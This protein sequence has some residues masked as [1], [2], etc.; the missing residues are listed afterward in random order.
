M[1][2]EGH[3]TYKLAWN[4]WCDLLGGASCDDVINSSKDRVPLCLK[5]PGQFLYPRQDL[6]L[7]AMESF[8]LKWNLILDLCRTLPVFYQV[9][10]LPHLGLEPVSL[11]VEIPDINKSWIPARWNFSLKLAD[12]KPADRLV[13]SHIPDEMICSLLL[14]PT[15]SEMEYRPNFVQA[16]PLGRE[17]GVTGLMKSFA[18]VYDNPQE[19][20]ALLGVDL[21]S[22]ILAQENFSDSDVFRVSLPLRGDASKIY[23]WAR[24][25]D[26]LERGIEVSGVT[27]PLTKEAWNELQKS[28]REVFS[29]A[30]VSVYRSFHVPCDIYSVGV[31]IFRALLVN[32]H[33][34]VRQV[35]PS[36]LRIV[37]GLNP[38]V[39]GLDSDNDATLYTRLR[40]R[41]KEEGTAFASTA[42]LYNFEHASPATPLIPDYLWYEAMAF[43]LRCISWIPGFS[44]CPNYAQNYDAKCILS[45]LQELTVSAEALSSRIRIELFE[46]KQRD[47]DVIEAS[48]RVRAE[49]AGMKKPVR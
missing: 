33:Q 9:C 29:Q 32:K 11:H 47:L 27:D 34:T 37:K 35:M 4:E 8:W 5:G 42:V 18:Q 39:E 28:T 16:W 38:I 46:S 2:L 36:L 20:R 6:T 15:L 26:A 40:S 31:L 13:D 43:G 49:L 1:T 41:M 23:M 21:I 48:R 17:I 19:W 24:K 12:G 10:N 44:V 14:P 25:I 30:T 7:S 22:D 45:L 3:E